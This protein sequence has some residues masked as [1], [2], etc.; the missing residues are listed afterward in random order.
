MAVSSLVF[1]G[2]DEHDIILLICWTCQR[3]P[4]TG[5]PRAH[6]SLK[7]SDYPADPGHRLRA[8]LFEPACGW[9]A[10]RQPGANNLNAQRNRAHSLLGCRYPTVRQRCCRG[11]A[12]SSRSGHTA[13]TAH[14]QAVS[15]TEH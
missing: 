6:L 14:E 8:R 1:L 7:I 9:C 13:D 12:P 2:L 3:S 5:W 10:Q 11:S 4:T 15:L